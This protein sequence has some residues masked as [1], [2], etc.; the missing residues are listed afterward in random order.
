MT[1]RM[2]LS[3]EPNTEYANDIDKLLVM[4]RINSYSANASAILLMHGWG[5]SSDIWNDCIES[6]RIHFDIYIL[7]LPGHGLNADS[8]FVHAEDFVEHF[9]RQH[10]SAMPQKFAIIGWSLGG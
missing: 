6:L 7:D 10:F 1:K 5:A 8:S 3:A 2:T 4:T 9:T